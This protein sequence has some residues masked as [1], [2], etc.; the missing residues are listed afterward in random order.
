MPYRLGGDG[1]DGAI[2]CIHLVYR[3]LELLEIDTP[4]FNEA[5]Y[6]MPTRA[7]L[8]DLLRWGKRIGETAYDGDVILLPADNWAFGVRW[9]DGILCVT[10]QTERVTWCPTDHVTGTVHCFRTRSSFAK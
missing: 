1:S 8:R 6:E 7:V 5:W 4:E 9:N 10:Q 3:V 2:D